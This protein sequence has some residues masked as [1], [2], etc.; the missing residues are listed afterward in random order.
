[1]QIYDIIETVR[2]NAAG[3]VHTYSQCECGR[4]SRRG[5]WPCNLCLAD[6]LIKAGVPKGYVELWL[7][8][9]DGVN[10]CESLFVDIIGEDNT[11]L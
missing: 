8:S 3:G 4:Q 1:M 11:E 2:H 6:K 9:L 7:V 5:G 10:K